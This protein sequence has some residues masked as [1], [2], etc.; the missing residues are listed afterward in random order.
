MPES[1]VF[2]EGPAPPCPSPF[3]LAAYVLAQAEMQ[4]DKPAL[5]IL[6]RDHS[7]V[8][9]YRDL[10]T[11]VLATCG[12]FQAQGFAP[13]SRVFLRLGNEIA[14]PVLF[15]GAIAAGLVPVPLS[16][17]LTDSELKRLIGMLRPSVM[18]V[19][20][21]LSVPSPGHAAILKA[22]DIA[23]MFAHRPGHMVSGSPED[24]AYIVLTS[25]TSGKAHAVCHAHRAVWARRMMW[26][27][28]YD[29]RPSD[30]LLHA[31]A[32]NWTFTLGTGLCDPWAIGA[33][34][35][36]PA[37]DLSA[38]DLRGLL[39]SSKATLFAAA[40]GVY[41]QMLKPDAPLSCPHLRHGLS[42][43]EKMPERL[44]AR[45]RNQT[46]RKVYE[47]LGMSEISTFVSQT[48]EKPHTQGAAGG[49]QQGRRAAVLDP[50]TSLPVP[51][52]SAGVLA[53]S[54][55][56]PGLMIGYFE[57]PQATQRKKSGEWF[58]TGDMVIM[59]RGGEITYLGRQ[60][61]MMNAGGYRVSPLEV[62][63]VLNLLPHLSEAAVTAIEIKPGTFVIAAFY[64][65]DIDLS[66]E[67]MAKHCA[68]HLARYK[69][70]RLFVRLKDIPKGANGKLRRKDLA[71]DMRK[72][73]DQTCCHL[74]SD[75]P[76][77]HDWNSQIR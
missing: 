74:G 14:F 8:W 45:W 33:T 50:E 76:L 18:C 57:D 22:K 27:G 58:L 30:R 12:A 52:G 61:D 19:G 24:I 17:Q 47:A 28:W 4:P 41:R 23:R 48:P 2:D 73:N 37:P 53:V 9:S 43:G 54:D 1:S 20:K 67:Q 40:P 11:A 31:G 56:D 26:S 29:L 55:R 5:E 69:C 32:F 10:R 72:N 68:Q 42:A 36:I 49:V 77:V 7:A 62:E 34:A 16:A 44:R 75:L 6:S 39:Q 51:I 70:P 21:D 38:V 59:G 60:D 15:L 63:D 13:Q 35:L 71:R 66:D 65:S 46:G 64:V 25:G 3:N